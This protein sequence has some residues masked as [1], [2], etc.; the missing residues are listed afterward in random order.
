MPKY[1]RIPNIC[2]TFARFFEK[3]MAR[4]RAV[5]ARQAHNLKVG[6]SIP[7]SATKRDDRKA[8]SLFIISRYCLDKVSTKLRY[9]QVNVSVVN[10]GYIRSI[11]INTFFLHGWKSYF[12]AVAATLYAATLLSINR[13]RDRKG[14]AILCFRLIRCPR[15][16][17]SKCHPRHFFTAVTEGYIL[18]IYNYVVF[19]RE[20]IRLDYLARIQVWLRP[21][22]PRLSNEPRRTSLPSLR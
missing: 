11:Y 6:G 12:M 14:R 19:D 21:R 1:L 4:S 8:V 20:K 10:G 13:Q 9:C 22:N 15:R 2:S 3:A 18:S 16:S 17:N 5:V 7:S